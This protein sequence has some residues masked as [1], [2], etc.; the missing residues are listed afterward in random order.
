MHVD[1]DEPGRAEALPR[2]WERSRKGNA[3]RKIDS[4][5]FVV[6]RHSQG[7][8]EGCYGLMRKGFN[9]DSFE[10]LSGCHESEEAAIEQ[11]NEH[12]REWED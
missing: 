12:F 6:F 10:F 5:L 2:Y 8:H 3:Y 4:C 7:P 1:Y 9:D 11:A